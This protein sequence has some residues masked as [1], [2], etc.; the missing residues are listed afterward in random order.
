MRSGKSTSVLSIATNQL[1]GRRL[2]VRCAYTV[3]MAADHDPNPKS[4]KNGRLGLR[5]NERQRSI[6]TAASQAEGT[7]VSEFVSNTPH[8][9]RKRCWPIVERLSWLNPSGLH[10]RKSWTANLETSR[11]FESYL[12]PRRYLTSLSE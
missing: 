5:I 3:P 1:G 6:L 10:L 12:R 2:C 9:Q 7:S 4:P 8:A 11:A